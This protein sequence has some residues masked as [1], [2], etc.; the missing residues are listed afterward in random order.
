ML[1]GSLTEERHNYPDGSESGGDAK[2]GFHRKILDTNNV[3]YIDDTIGV[4]KMIN[5]DQRDAISLHIYAPPY[6]ECRIFGLE[7]QRSFPNVDYSLSSDRHR[8]NQTFSIVRN[9]KT[10]GDTIAL[11][12]P[13]SGKVVKVEFYSD[14]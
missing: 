11:A 1:C 2:Q 9:Y 4:H 13:I 8:H 3:H 10:V 7:W 12:K 14:A 6:R 5:C